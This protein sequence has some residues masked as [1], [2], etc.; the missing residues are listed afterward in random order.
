ML[1][2]RVVAV[3]LV[4]DAVVL[5]VLIVPVSEV[6]LLAVVVRMPMQMY[7]YVGLGDAV[8]EL[9][10]P[11]YTASFEATCTHVNGMASSV[12]S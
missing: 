9:E 10:S 8:S 5:I 4:L 12:K 1:L 11:K 2:V 7:R 3:M 6:V